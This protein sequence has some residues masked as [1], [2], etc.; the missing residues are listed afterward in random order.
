MTRL[1]KVIIISTIFIAIIIIGSF[2]LMVRFGTNFMEKKLLSIINTEILKPLAG[3]IEW[4]RVKLN[5]LKNELVF[6]GVSFYPTNFTHTQVRSLSLSAEKIH[7]RYSLKKVFSTGQLFFPRV[8]LEGLRGRWTPGEAFF[9]IGEADEKIPLSGELIL[10][11]LLRANAFL[12]RVQVLDGSFQV[13]LPAQVAAGN[14]I[15]L[16]QIELA[17][18]FS[19]KGLVAV[20][21]QAPKIEIIASGQ[22][23]SFILEA[24][25][26]L[27]HKA[28][29]LDAFSLA[30]E[31]GGEKIDLEGKLSYPA[32][33]P[34]QLAAFYKA[35]LDWRRIEA[36]WP[37]LPAAAL[38][39]LLIKG[40]IEGPLEA[41]L[42]KGT[43]EVARLTPHRSHISWPGA[44][45]EA[46][47]TSVAQRCL[48]LLVPKSS[49][50]AGNSPR[51]DKLV[52]QPKPYPEI[53]KLKFRYLV[54]KGKITLSQ[55]SFSTL[56]GGVLGQA[57]ISLP[58]R[59]ISLT[60]SLDG[61]RLDH[62]ELSSPAHNFYFNLIDKIRRRFPELKGRASFEGKLLPSRGLVGSGEL[63][64]RLNGRK[65]FEGP[66]FWK[67]K[68]SLVGEKNLHF[69]SSNL[70]L[71]ENRLDFRG[72]LFT[73][74]TGQGFKDFSFDLRLKNLSS[75]SSFWP[76]TREAAGELSFSGK[77]S[78]PF[79][80]PQLC[81]LLIWQNAAFGRY[82]AQR[83]EGRIDYD[84]KFIALSDVTLVQ[85]KTHISIEGKISATSGQGT[86]HAEADPI[87]YDD[88]EK[89]LTLQA[90]VLIKGRMRC[91]S[92]FQ[93]LPHTPRKFLGQ[94][95]VTT[96]EWSIAD[97]E[98]PYLWQRFDSVTSR[99][100]VD[101]QSFH[102]DQTV[103]YKGKQKVVA[104]L[105]IPHNDLGPNSLY[106]F[107]SDDWSLDLLDTIRE[108]KIPLRGRASFQVQGSGG[109]GSGDWSWELVVQKP[110]YEGFSLNQLVASIHMQA[111]KYWGELS[112]GENIFSVQGKLGQGISYN[113]DGQIP[114]L[115]VEPDIG[116]LAR[117]IQTRAPYQD[118]KTYYTPLAGEKIFIELSGKVKASGYLADFEHS[119]GEFLA[120][121]ATVHTPLY[122][123]RAKEPFTIVYEQGRISLSDS[124]FSSGQEQ[125]IEARLRGSANQHRQLDFSLSGAIPMSC[126]GE[127]CQLFS[128]STGNLQFD[129]FLKGPIDSPRVFG[130]LRPVDCSLPIPQLNRRI[131]A[132]GG[133]LLIDGQTITIVN[134][135]GR[136]PDGRLSLS[137]KM[138]WQDL[139]ISS[140]D[141][142]LRGENI[143]LASPSRYQFI[144]SGD[145]HLQGDK[146]YS[147]LSGVINVREGRYYRDTGFLQALLSRRRRIEIDE[148]ILSSFQSSATEWLGNMSCDLKVNIPQNVWIKSAF[149]TAEVAG[150]EFFIKGNFP[151]PYPDGQIRTTNG[152]ILLGGNKFQ[153]V[154]GVLE[155]T[156][157]QRHNPS[158]DILAVAE[159]DNYQISA[160]I[161]GSV[162][163]PQ[164]R[165]SSTPYLSQ[166][167]ILN[168]IALG[169]SASDGVSGEGD[170]WA[171]EQMT[172]GE[173]PILSDIFG[174]Q[175]TSFSGLDLFRAKLLNRDL[176][177]V[178]IFKFKVGEES[179]AVEKITVGRD[180]TKR[181]QL[182]YSIP[183]SVEERETAEAGYRL[184]D[185]IRLIGSQDALG[186]YSLDLNFSF[187]F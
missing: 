41:P 112:A 88:L 154:S 181:L 84:K 107:A 116:Y 98:H 72:E 117:V 21:V 175:V 105:I 160:N 185:Y 111:D 169:I 22:D 76:L 31:G 166:T 146:E 87:Y 89:I 75:L 96:A 170:D 4:E 64:L 32:D 45:S 167:D 83:I 91:T 114:Q 95:Q 82:F 15:S 86:L 118:P 133:E 50:A 134:L 152:T 35:R 40:K 149:L 183:A 9:K 173:E 174:N 162:D 59:A 137:G 11:T 128:G 57:V 155:L 123:F 115:K 141:L 1:K 51:G 143:I 172:I 122:H 74:A 38:S 49:L 151:N 144:I 65:P 78:G 54:E 140:V 26:H 27:D 3:H 148:K 102:L 23:E 153:I 34:L 125:G 150:S 44:S 30:T 94:G 138:E 56:S 73:S 43:V 132:I 121:Q 106:R 97:K 159:I 156:D 14:R 126:L 39:P 113:L 131:E 177:R 110:Q 37:H 10:G 130:R 2:P 19:S 165:L 79:S 145:V 53:D 25:L 187:E 69:D 24:S 178:D 8:R 5:L 127:K 168:M 81:G 176:F 129:F 52:G 42:L 180:I 108:Q 119:A 158:V 104:E 48:A 120:A 68:F 100:E 6:E 182:K 62:C 17:L 136:Y 157:P 46:P 90:P 109:I 18:D 28:L 58:E 163:D 186:T 171:K 80:D 135:A 12:S 179:G 7:A 55:F 164:I 63:D 77:M 13:D 85:N 124:W 61:L 101:G 139:A 142:N 71:A 70:K 103:G 93:I 47:T 16:R 92:D 161:F 99:F 67:T 36:L 60:A 29:S 184:S 66:L 20:Q 147:D 33:K